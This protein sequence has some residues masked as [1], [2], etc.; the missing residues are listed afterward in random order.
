M[1]I[2]ESYSYLDP[3]TFGTWD[4][5]SSPFI[6]DGNIP[7][8]LQLKEDL[9]GFGFYWEVIQKKYQSVEELYEALSRLYAEIAEIKERYRPI[10]KEYGE[11]EVVPNLYE[12]ISG[13]YYLVDENGEKQFLIKPLDEEAGCIHSS[14]FPTLF[15][16]CPLRAHIELYLSSMREVLAYQI[17]EMIGTPV[18]PKTELGIITSD[19]FQDFSERVTLD[20]LKRYFDNCPPVQSE[21]ICS[22][23]EYVVGSKSLFEAL[24]DFQMAG[25]SDLEIEKRFDKQD[26]EDAN[27][28]LWV[29]NDTDGHMG[30]FLVYPKGVDAIGNEILGIKKIDNGL[31]FPDKN[32]QLQNNLALLPNA[33]MMLTEEGRAKIDAIDIEKMAE[34][35]EKLG[36]SSATIA[37][38]ERITHLKQLAQKPNITI[39]EINTEMSKL[40]KKR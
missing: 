31:A 16:D 1:E 24:H 37:M 7:D 33:K 6:P 29:T 17:A 12:G 4:S 25:L 19:K 15:K 34:K 36:L 18:V 13:S 35:Y 27:I 11:F 3:F 22:V 23:Q 32:G 28:L 8:D 38:K 9:W 5:E 30:N 14:W 21:K 2:T 10:A 40:G 39:K 20:E 26:F